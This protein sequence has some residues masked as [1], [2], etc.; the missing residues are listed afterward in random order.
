ME[1]TTRQILALLNAIDEIA[2]DEVDEKTCIP[3]SCP[4]NTAIATITTMPVD[5]L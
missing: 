4:H 3:Y 5:Q 1:A 2:A